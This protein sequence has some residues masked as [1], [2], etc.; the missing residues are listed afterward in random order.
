M[1]IAPLPG[2]DIVAD[3]N[4]HPYPFENEAYDTI[5]CEDVLEHLSD[6]EGCMRELHRVLKKGGKLFISVPH[7]SS[8]DNFIDPSH[9]K[10][11]SASTFGYFVKNHPR[12]YYYD[13]HF[14][15]LE[16]L[17]SR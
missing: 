9:K 11:F 1:D 8:A 7:F 3:L 6:F 5:F 10:M 13:F 17:L 4:Q 15:K 12:N 16:S 2:V 14:I